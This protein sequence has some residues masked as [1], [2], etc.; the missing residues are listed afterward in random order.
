MVGLYIKNRVVSWNVNG[1][2]STKIA[3]SKQ[4]CLTEEI[5]CIQEHFLSADDMKLFNTVSSHVLHFVS[6]KSPRNRGHPSDG[7]ATI[8]DRHTNSKQFVK[9]DHFLVVKVGDNV[10][11]NVYL[12]TD[13]KRQNS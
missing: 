7:L 12:Q 9:S 5:L 1:S 2:F 13:Y 11:V 6:T 10:I 8:I 3:M 4:R